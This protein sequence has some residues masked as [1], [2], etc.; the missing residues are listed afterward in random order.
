MAKL[1]AY[2]KR[3][4]NQFKQPGL[5][6]KKIWMFLTKLVTRIFIRFFSNSRHLFILDLS[7]G[8]DQDLYSLHNFENS[9]DYAKNQKVKT[10]KKIAEGYDK[11]WCSEE[12][13]SLIT[14][15]MVGKFGEQEFKGICHGTRVGKEVEWFN[16][17]LPTGSYV[18]GTDI[19][20]SATKF[21]NTIE[22][23]F[24]EVKDEW[25]NSFDFIYSNSQDHA[26][27]PKKAIGNW[28]ASINEKGFLFLEINRSHGKKFQDDADCWGVETEIL[29]FL[30]L[31]WFGGDFAVIDMIPVKESNAHYILVL[32]R[33]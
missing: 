28:L 20:P 24:H 10:S 18:F 32:A 14:S 19:E 3:I 4:T 25:L 11:S 22:H 33:I 1:K 30:L 26:K 27:N 2:I 15:Y 23:D 7:K 6:P 31:Q 17:H 9:S 13:I 21:S 5:L 16:N 29:P 8:S 12:T